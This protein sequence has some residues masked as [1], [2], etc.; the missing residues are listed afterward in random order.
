M[1]VQQYLKK[2]YGMHPGST[3]PTEFL[4]EELHLNLNEVKQVVK[5]ILERK[6]YPTMIAFSLFCMIC[7]TYLDE[8]TV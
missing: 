4:E 3:I 8:V 1:P 5:Q 7:S 6:T 2:K